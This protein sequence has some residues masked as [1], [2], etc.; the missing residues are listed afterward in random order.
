M[1]RERSVSMSLR[2]LRIVGPVR[3]VP[4]FTMAPAAAIPRT[5]MERTVRGMRSVRVKGRGEKRGRTGIGKHPQNRVRTA[6][7]EQVLDLQSSEKL[8]LVGLVLLE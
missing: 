5:G 7:S 8:K 1:A 3:G 2:E 4:I 6:S